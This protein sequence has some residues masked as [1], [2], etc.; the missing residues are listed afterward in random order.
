MQQPGQTYHR[1]VAVDILQSL[2][3]A[4]CE[5]GES[6]RKKTLRPW[7]AIV[8]MTIGPEWSEEKRRSERRKERRAIA[9]QRRKKKRRGDAMSRRLSGA[10]EMGKHR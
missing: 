3:S 10:Y 9:K 6:M 7:I 2:G 5:R 4:G 1:V 8:P